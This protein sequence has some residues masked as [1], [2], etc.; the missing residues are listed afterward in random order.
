MGRGEDT[1][2]VT[3]IAQNL[4]I[5]VAVAAACAW[6]FLRDTNAEQS[7]YNR[8]SREEDLGSLVVEFMGKV[9]VRVWGGAGEW[10]P[11]GSLRECACVRGVAGTCLC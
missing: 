7:I 8:L 11:I 9:S 3:E 1:A 2:A 10:P 6:A 4:G 5:D